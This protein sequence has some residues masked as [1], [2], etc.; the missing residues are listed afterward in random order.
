M[1]KSQRFWTIEAIRGLDLIA[2]YDVP[3]HRLEKTDVI[4]LLKALVVKYEDV[5]FAAV[6]NAFLNNRKGGQLKY[7]IDEPQ[8]FMNLEKAH[9]GYHVFGPTV[10]ACARHPISAEAVEFARKN[11]NPVAA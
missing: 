2:R 11:R 4:Q 10:Y 8:Y 3:L 1:P 5:E 7:L 9:V 6:V